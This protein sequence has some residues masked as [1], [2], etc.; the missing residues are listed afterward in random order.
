MFGGNYAPRNYAYCNGQILA[1][2]QNSALFS[3]LGATFGGN[4]STTFGLPDLRGRVPIHQ[5]A[6][7]GL[8]A[9]SRGQVGGVET[10]P[11]AVTQLPNHTHLAQGDTAGGAL[12]TPVAGAIWSSVPRGHPAPYVTSGTPVAMSAAAVGTS[13]GGQAHNNR[14][15]YQAV[16][17]IIATS[18]VYPSRS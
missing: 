3:L 14:S 12:A 5:G 6:G 13:G 8:S 15:P 2:Q 7:P 9:Y 11:L 4:G 17:F 10:V 1:V 18:G 16:G